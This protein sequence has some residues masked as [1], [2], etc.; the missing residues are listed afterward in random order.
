MT[1]HRKTRVGEEHLDAPRDDA[2]SLS[3]VNDLNALFEV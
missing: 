2:A 1:T 3:S